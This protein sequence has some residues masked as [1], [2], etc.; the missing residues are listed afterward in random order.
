MF[1]IL[2]FLNL[3]KHQSDICVHCLITLDSSSAV[4]FP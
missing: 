1:A 2:Y 3:L 4:V